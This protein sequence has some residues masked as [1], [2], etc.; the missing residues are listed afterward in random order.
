M[1]R[2]RNFGMNTTR[3]AL[4]GGLGLA[5][6]CVGAAAQ[7]APSLDLGTVVVSAN[8]TPTEEAA[9]G[10]AVTVIT[11]AQIEKSGETLA[12]D[13]LSH[14]PG[15]GFS[16]AGPMGSQTTMEMRG[17]GA[18]Y[19]LV[20]IDG[21]DVSDPTQPQ[22]AATL[23]NLLLGDV[24][25]IE[26]LRGSQSAL[27]G[28]TA[29]AGVVDITTRT[30]AEKGIHHSVTVGG[31]SYGTVSGRYGFSAAND[32]VEVATSVERI[33]SDGF[34][35]A[36]ERA[37]NRE[38]DGYD[39]LTASAN[40]AWRISETF[41]VFA[42]LRYTRRYSEY[43]DFTYDFLTG[44][45]HPADETGARFHTVAEEI[46]AR[47]GADF[48]LFDGRLDNK[49]AI[50]HYN[51]T[52]DVWDSYPGHYEGKRTKI[53]Y[54]GNW[55]FNDAIGLS[56]G[57]DHGH[58]QADTSGGLG[59]SV[60]NTGVFGQISWKP[61]TGLTLTGALRDDHHST[62]GDHVTHRL[63]AAWEATET[64]KLRA[65]WGSGFRP[66]SLYEL[67]APFYGNRAL[68]PEQSNSFDAGIDQRFWNGRAT[69]SATVFHIDTA[70]LIDYDSATWAFVQIPG[71][72]RR[73]G[74]ELSAKLKLLDT[75]T[76]DGGYTYTDARA[77]SG[78]RLVRVPRHKATLGA[79]WNALER[80]TLTLRGTLVSDSVDTDWNV[81]AVRRLPDYVLVDAGITHKIDDR[82][83]V[84][85]TGKN[86]LDR[87]YQTIWGYGTPGASV[88][89]SLT[90]RY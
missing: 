19:V 42:S 89:A 48:K 76:L 58:E 70:D 86:L 85:L 60:D 80:T 79:A 73:D 77:A 8:R 3:I 78:T 11:R 52:R 1:T 46:G 72:S 47:T 40:A 15:I 44:F 49:I 27:Y 84:S 82:I 25:R 51:I 68:K 31:G 5:L 7:E 63:T 9:V 62:F 14:V 32:A 12:K 35:S 90:A 39:N 6:A 24:D 61:F 33:H 18:R 26:I 10:S 37:G 87:H 29:V 81:G 57:A 64:T 55:A 59:G 74:V 20:R 43:D 17:L 41:R 23:E 30:A 75:V 16:Q 65:S 67:Y 54:L 83:S 69:V 88:Y 4:G 53:E 36:D 50:Q 13:L 45:G 66:P 71:T 2:T 56:F 21:V 38:R 28:G 22:M 34:S